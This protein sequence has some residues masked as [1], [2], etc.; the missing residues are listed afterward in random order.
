MLRDFGDEYCYITVT[1]SGELGAHVLW[2]TRTHLA[3]LR[4]ESMHSFL[5]RK[6]PT[7]GAL[8]LHGGDEGIRTLGLCLAKAALS[9]LS[10][11]PVC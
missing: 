4:Y 5:T 1:Q 2:G 8:I 10:Y 7:A 6:R 11:I 9:Q 3:A